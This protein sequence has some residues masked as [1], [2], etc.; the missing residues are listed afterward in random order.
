MLVF[1]WNLYYVQ[2]ISDTIK[3]VG[4]IL[5]CGVCS[6][7]NC[8]TTGLSFVKFPSVYISSTNPT[9]Q[10]TWVAG[11]SEMLHVIIIKIDTMAFCN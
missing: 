9:Q 7:Y 1:N 6:W 10:T 8:L 4:Y 3:C 2:F 5:Y 11:Q